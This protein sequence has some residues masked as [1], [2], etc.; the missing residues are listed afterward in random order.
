VNRRVPVAVV[1]FSTILRLAFLLPFPSWYTLVAVVTSATV[2]MYAGAPL[3]V[4]VTV[5]P[6]RQRASHPMRKESR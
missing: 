2:L 3:A 5:A 1:I 6:H 4:A